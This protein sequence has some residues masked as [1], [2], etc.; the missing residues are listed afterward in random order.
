MDS[1]VLEGGSGVMYRPGRILKAGSASNDG[2]TP[3]AASSATAYVL[4]MNQPTPAWRAT[5]SMRFARTFHNLTSLADGTVL[6]TS[7]SQRKS[8][9]NLTP[10]VLEAELWSPGTESWTT[11]APMRTPRI[12]HSTAVLLPDGRVAVSGSGNIAGATDM[13]NLE[14]FS[15]PYLFKGPRPVVSSAPARI[16][17]GS[18][19]TVTTPNAQDIRL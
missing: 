16:E 2:A 10:A 12:Y 3:T 4:D 19:F 17:Y 7:G 18:T 8:E 11:M 9:T 15:P 6:V 13:K 1:R 14:T 5:A